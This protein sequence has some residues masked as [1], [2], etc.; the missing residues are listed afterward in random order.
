[1]ADSNFMNTHSERT[2]RQPVDIVTYTNVSVF[3]RGA[4]IGV[5]QSLDRSETRPMQPIQEMGTENVVE[6]VPGNTTGG[7]LRASRFLLYN[8]RFHQL[9][10]S[11]DGIND[12]RGVLFNNLYQQRIPFEIHVQTRTPNGQPVNET[13]VDCWVSDY[14]RS[15]TVGTITI[16]EN[17]TI[18]Y[19]VVL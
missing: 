6:I 14:S 17:C 3:L 7:T 8:N 16:S 10:G 13:F 2:N 19:A 1:M 15:Y 9:L 4:R 5:I 18:A 11:V 12:N